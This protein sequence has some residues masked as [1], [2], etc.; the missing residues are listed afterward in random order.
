MLRRV[1]ATHPLHNW[2]IHEMRSVTDM[3]CSAGYHSERIRI[4]A[5]LNHMG[6]KFWI[7]VYKCTMK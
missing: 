1:E 4:K 6:E 3:V 2:G 7:V 5:Q